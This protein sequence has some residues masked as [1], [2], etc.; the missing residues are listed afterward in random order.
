MGDSC[1]SFSMRERIFHFE[2]G[3]KEE[4]EKEDWTREGFNVSSCLEISNDA[5]QLSA[6]V[7][8]PDLRL[9][10]RDPFESEDPTSEHGST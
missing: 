3:K 2:R 1:P 6:T 7:N 9:S 5:L 10:W 8:F 4:K